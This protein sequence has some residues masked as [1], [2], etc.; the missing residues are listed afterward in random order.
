MKDRR[1]RRCFD[2][3]PDAGWYPPF[4]TLP[5]TYSYAYKDGHD[6][7]CPYGRALVGAVISSHFE[8]TAIPGALSTGTPGLRGLD[9]LFVTRRA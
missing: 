4:G 8:P 9:I 6:V 1:S 3:A 5:V 2:S 7:S